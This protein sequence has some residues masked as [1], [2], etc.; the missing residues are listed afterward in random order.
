M[1]I[2]G[3]LTKEVERVN[4]K[5]RGGG[6]EEVYFPCLNGPIE[7]RVKINLVKNSLL[8]LPN[9]EGCKKLVF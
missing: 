9:L 4:K 2:L 3:A 8:V 6:G 1:A 7:N 5:T